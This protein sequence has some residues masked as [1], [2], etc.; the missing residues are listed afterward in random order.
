MKAVSFAPGAIQNVQQDRFAAQEAG[1]K[2]LTGHWFA[3]RHS[4]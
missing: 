2:P 3:V 4:Q 1:E